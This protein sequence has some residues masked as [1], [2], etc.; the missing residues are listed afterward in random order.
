M[1]RNIVINNDATV[2]EKFAR[3]L[4]VCRWSPVAAIIIYHISVLGVTNVTYIYTHCN[5]K[6]EK[7]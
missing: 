7:S 6:L 4:T 3:Q 2:V 5:E 1:Y